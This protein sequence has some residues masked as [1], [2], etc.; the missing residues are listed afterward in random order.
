MLSEKFITLKFDATLDSPEF[1]KIRQKYAIV[2][3]PT[4]IFYS[5]KGEWLKELTLSEF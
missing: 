4:V 1:A 3:L 5:A 2:G